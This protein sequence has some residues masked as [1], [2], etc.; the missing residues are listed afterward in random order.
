MTMRLFYEAMWIQKAGSPEEEYEDAFWP[1]RSVS[2]ES[3]QK[4][5]FAI[6]DGATE[7]S[8]S[9]VWAKQL[10]RRILSGPNRPLKDEHVP[11]SE[12]TGV[13]AV[14][15]QKATSLVRGGKDSER[16]VLDD[17]RTHVGCWQREWALGCME[18][19]CRWG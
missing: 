15:R 4:E 11:S 16:N 17:S 14:R 3:R 18:R 6:A 9:G 19:F 5:T 10:V 12:A 13:G 8:F 2:G 1:R 7:S